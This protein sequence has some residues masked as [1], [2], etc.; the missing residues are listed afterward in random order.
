M[1]LIG[2]FTLY[3]VDKALNLSGNLNEKISLN[4]VRPHLPSF[5]ILRLCF[6]SLQTSIQNFFNQIHILIL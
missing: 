5:V 4:K 6:G 2:G 3:S 1:V